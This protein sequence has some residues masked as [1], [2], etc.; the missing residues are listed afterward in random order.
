MLTRR[1]FQSWVMVAFGVSAAMLMGSVV[2]P[3]SRI[4]PRSEELVVSDDAASPDQD[5]APPTILKWSDGYGA[6][7]PL[8][9]PLVSTTHTVSIVWVNELQ[10]PHHSCVSRSTA[11]RAPP[12]LA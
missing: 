1:V 10:D 4:D 12:I 2:I 11:P 7:P 3:H 5:S 8:V 6:T 9:L